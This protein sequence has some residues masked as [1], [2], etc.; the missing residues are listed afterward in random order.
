MSH[1]PTTPAVASPLP[2]RVMVRI[3]IVMLLGLGIIASLFG[4]VQ[5]V[6]M[7][8]VQGLGEFLPISSL[9]HL[10]LT[11]WF[12]GWQGGTIDTLTFDVAL[13]LGTLIAV[14]AYFWRDWLAL[15]RA[16]PG[17]LSG[18][19]AVLRGAST[20]GATSDEHLLTLL[21]VATIPGGIAGVLLDSWAEHALRAPLLLA[22]TLPVLGLLLYTA[23]RL[24]PQRTTFAQMSWRTALL[25]GVAQA[26]A[27][28]PGVSRSGVTITMGRALTLDRAT[29]ARFSFL[30][31]APITAAAVLFK[32]PAILHIPSAEM[33]TFAIGVVVSGLVGALAI[34]GLLSYIRHAGFGVFAAYRAALA[35]AIVLVY[36]V[37]GG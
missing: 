31:S 1:Q 18:L 2:N 35:V 19:P 9:A 10:I 29:A 5:P 3:I 26:C 14:L 33:T 13:H 34:S 28:I 24:Q 11:P 27:I 4:D 16:L 30:L 37:R 20:H 17:W 7:G 21:V 6:V 15:L 12:F 25:I 8:M 23:D 36:L 32:L 22:V